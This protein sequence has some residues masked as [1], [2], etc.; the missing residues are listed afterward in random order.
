MIVYDQ[1]SLTDQQTDLTDWLSN[2][3]FDLQGTYMYEAVE[4]HV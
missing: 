3:V 4:L 2:T 1:L